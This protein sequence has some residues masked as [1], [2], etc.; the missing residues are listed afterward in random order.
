MKEIKKVGIVGLG[1]MG[2][3]VAQVTA[4]AGYQV[5]GIESNSQALTIGSQRIE[6]SLKKMIT[7]D[8]KNKKLTENEG[9]Q[10]FGEVMN[11]IRLTTDINDAYDCDLIIEAIIE[12]MDVKLKFYQDIAKKIKPDA[13]FASNTS[14]LQITNMALAS[15]RPK[16][17]VGLHFFNPGRLYLLPSFSFPNTPP[18]SPPFLPLLTLQFK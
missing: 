3:G 14:S 1:L 12:N 18:S 9:N 6:Q 16:N 5:L 13:I 7:K 15:Q 2:H 8:V 10:T 4:Q 11:R 17:F